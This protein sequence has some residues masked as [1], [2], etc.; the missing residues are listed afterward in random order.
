MKI[1]RCR[2]ERQNPN[3]RNWGLGS[4]CMVRA[5]KKALYEKQTNQ[6]IGFSTLANQL[7]RFKSFADW[8]K[9]VYGINDM[10]EINKHHVIEYAEQLVLRVEDPSDRL[11]SYTSAANYLSAVNSVLSQA[12]GD[13]QLRFTGKE[14]GY[15]DRDDIL[16]ENKTITHDQHM[17]AKEL[18]EP[19]LAAQMGLMRQLGLRFEGACKVNAKLALTLAIQHGYVLIDCEKNH[20]PRKVSIRNTE[21]IKA[22]EESASFQG[23]HH[24]LI[25][26]D[27][28]YSE[29]S[30]YCY[31][32]FSA[33]DG[34][35]AHSERRY[36]AQTLYSE[37]IF[38]LT[39]TQGVQCP[40][41]AKVPHG[42]AH[43]QYLAEKLNLPLKETKAIDRQARKIVSLELGH[44][45]I[46]ITN[47]YIG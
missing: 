8:L 27:K 9:S 26:E 38:K 20:T 23:N 28:S 1:P 25:P 37:T 24:S 39:N 29:Y 33:I 2:N 45:R 42:K 10:R 12:R 6:V 17:K 43:Y 47:S 22:L 30:S 14:A 5:A 11:Q 34:Y 15:P 18:V 35:L 32:Q 3:A 44:K 31:R 16:R 46:S 13:N 41:V 19:R 36:F 40:V 4:R 7:T 21:Q